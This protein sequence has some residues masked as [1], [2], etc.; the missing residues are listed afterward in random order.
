[1][2]IIILHVNFKDIFNDK[3]SNPKK[4][5]RKINQWDC[6]KLKRFITTKGI[7]TQT[8]DSL[9]KR[10]SSHTKSYKRLITKINKEFTKINNNKNYKWP[11][12]QKGT[13]HEHSIYQ[14]ISPKGHQMYEKM[15]QVIEMQIKDNNEIPLHPSENV[16]HKK[17]Q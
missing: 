9:Q 7:N 14:R 11:H 5:K 13:G 16:T 12:S 6:I 2:G 10:R 4:T 1:M 15:S 8:K 17:E 3:D